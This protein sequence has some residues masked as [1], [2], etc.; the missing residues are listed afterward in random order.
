[1]WQARGGPI[2]RRGR[3][4]RCL[5]PTDLDHVG[6]VGR[7]RDRS[8]DVGDVPKVQNFHRASGQ[9]MR[10]MNFYICPTMWRATWGG[11]NR[12]TWAM[13]AMSPS[14]W[15]MWATWGV[16]GTSR[17]VSSVSS[18]PFRVYSCDWERDPARSRTTEK[19]EDVRDV[20]RG[21][22]STCLLLSSFSASASAS[23]QITGNCL[24]VTGVTGSGSRCPS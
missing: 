7:G 13:W 22:G 1:M 2:D 17:L 8:T 24:R 19:R 16:G 18:P 15:T 12:P 6:D 21:K 4:G 5:R 9:P 14:T 10:K 23:F 11:T 20:K 3:C